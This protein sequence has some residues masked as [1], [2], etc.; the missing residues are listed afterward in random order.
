MPRKIDLT[1]QSGS[2]GRKGRWRKKYRGKAYYFACGTSKSDKDG[3]RQAL[4]AWMQKKAE[5][6]REEQSRARPHQEAYEEAIREWTLVIQW[7]R[8]NSDQPQAALAL[9]KV[10][11]LQ[12]RLATAHPPPL[13]HDDR[14][15][16]QFTFPPEMLAAV[17]SS[18]DATASMPGA[19]GVICVPSAR[20]IA[21]LDGT[22]GR[23]SRE[24][25]QDRLELQRRKNVLPQESVGANITTFLAGER[26]RVTAGEITAGRYDPLRTHLEHFRGWL[27]ADLPLSSI[28]SKVLL[29]YH[30]ELLQGM[31]G[32][33][34]QWSA[35]YAKDR[36]NAVKQFVRWLWRIEAVEELPRVLL[37]KKALRISKKVATPPVFTIAEVKRLLGAANPRSRLYLL[38]MLNTG[39]GQKDISDLRQTEMDWKAGRITRKRSKTAKHDTVPTVSYRLWGETLRLLKQER[40]TDGEVVLLN[41]AG[42]RLKVEELDADGRLR[43]IDNISTA[44]NRLK[45]LVKLTKPLKTFRKTSATLLRGEKGFTGVEDLFLGHAPRSIADRHYAQVPQALLDEA[46]AWLG[47]QYGVK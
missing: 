25:W 15:W 19:A 16:G 38:L 3:Y 21:S 42:G 26:A 14:I 20:A 33:A 31:T 9:R 37:D 11:V 13:G 36:M 39:M 4:E 10:E 46:I 17:G 44:F 34:P 2:A 43:K 5:L 6:D 32:A 29:D 41:A 40:A 45:R 22:P 1:W 7:A 24:I 8:E 18:L 12:Q 30:A 28:T 35:D 27:G 23:I 47:G